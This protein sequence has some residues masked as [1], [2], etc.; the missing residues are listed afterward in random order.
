MSPDKKYKCN[1]KKIKVNYIITCISDK[2]QFQAEYS[3][4]SGLLSYEVPCQNGVCRYK[5][6]GNYGIFSRNFF[7]FYK[8]LG[9]DFD[10]TMTGA[11]PILDHPL[12]G[13]DTASNSV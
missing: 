11:K 6:Y 12:V 8:K 5:L 2:S 7:K 13:S 3:F 4:I 1:K 10:V 9:I